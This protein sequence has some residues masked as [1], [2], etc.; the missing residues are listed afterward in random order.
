MKATIES[1]SLDFGNSLV[2]NTMLRTFAR[3]GRACRALASKW[4]M[5]DE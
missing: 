3:R 4:A 1:M 2:S 5:A